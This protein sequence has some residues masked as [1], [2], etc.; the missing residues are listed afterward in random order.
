MDPRNAIHFRMVVIMVQ[1]D[2][3]MR[4]FG[5]LLIEAFAQILFNEIN[6]LRTHAGLQPRTWQQF[7]DEINNHLSTLEPYDWMTE[8]PT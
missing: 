5:P 8:K 1:R 7:S 2:E 6:F 4:K 3:L